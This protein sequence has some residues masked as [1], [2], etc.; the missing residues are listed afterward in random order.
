LGDSGFSLPEAV[1]VIVVVGILAVISVMGMASTMTTYRLNSAASKVI[2][3][4]RYAQQ[5]ARAHATWYGVQF[6]VDPSNTYHVYQTDG[7]TDT[8][9][10][11]PHNRATTLTVNLESDYDVTISAANIAGG[12]KVEFNPMGTP[13]SDELGAALVASGSV[14]LSCG[15]TSRTIQIIRGTG[16][17]E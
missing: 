1:I 10:T 17:A 8:D 7:V 5:M 14:T 9:V 2:S 12:D 4:I 16:R 15:G 6:G 11:S 13:Y 3:D